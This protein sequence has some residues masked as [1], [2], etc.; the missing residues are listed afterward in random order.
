MTTGQ[1]N[2]PGYA[3]L[4]QKE[5]ERAPA[6]PPPAYAVAIEMPTAAVTESK[7][8]D[9]LCDCCSDCGSCWHAWC[10]PWVSLAQSSHKIGYTSC[11]KVM[12]LWL[13]LGLTWCITLGVGNHA[14][15]Q[16]FEA[17]KAAQVHKDPPHQASRGQGARRSPEGP[18]APACRQCVRRGTRW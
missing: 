4:K 16:Q 8:K 2:Y 6:P 11:T 17:C 5:E 10:C 3:A 14:V 1:A 13:L 18:Q 15:Y 9:G 12:L 7:F